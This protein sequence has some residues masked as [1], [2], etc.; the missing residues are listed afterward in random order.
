MSS[1]YLVLLQRIKNASG[2][3]LELSAEDVAGDGADL[4]YAMYGR[5]W[6]RPGYID[7]ELNPRCVFYWFEECNVEPDP[8]SFLNRLR[9]LQGSPQEWQF[10]KYHRLVVQLTAPGLAE[11]L[12]L[13]GS[14]EK[15]PQVEAEDQ[16]GPG[17]SSPPADPRT[18]GEQSGQ[19][20]EAAADAGAVDRSNLPPSRL[21]AAAVYEWA[22]ETIEGADKIPLRDLFPQILNKLD[23]TIAAKP[24]GAGEVEKLQQLRDSL[25]PNSEAFGKYL[26]DAGIKRYNTQGE[27]IRRMSHF[28]R[29]DEA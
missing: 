21:K 3:W 2:D 15:E 7:L 6:I 29:Q 9:E 22:I 12:R 5:N 27:R 8:K 25:P 26:R 14:P 13:R 1:D 11:Y 10:L 23:S 18:A 17:E 28:K 16:V 24:P 20:A 19:A 4:L